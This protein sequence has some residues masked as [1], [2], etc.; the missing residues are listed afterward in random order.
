MILFTF[1]SN[2]IN[3]HSSI[4][5]DFSFL[6][7]QSDSGLYQLV[8]VVLVFTAVCWV[9]D[10]SFNHQNVKRCHYRKRGEEGEESVPGNSVS[11]ATKGY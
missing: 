1:W 8:A 3:V 5:L 11:I 4:Y 6:I 7:E 2:Q 9:D 10:N